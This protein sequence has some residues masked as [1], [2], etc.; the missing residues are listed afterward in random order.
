MS[1]GVVDEFVQH[2]FDPGA[3]ERRANGS[4]RP[5]A[6]DQAATSV[7]AGASQQASARSSAVKDPV[8]SDR[9]ATGKVFSVRLI[10]LEDRGKYPP[11]ARLPDSEHCTRAGATNKIACT[12]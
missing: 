7:T 4:H 5:E 11:L 10:E 3:G 9:E 2:G 8:R 1:V 12:D 6:E